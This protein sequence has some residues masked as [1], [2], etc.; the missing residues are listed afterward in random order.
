[1]KL[2]LIFFISLLSFSIGTFVGKQ[3]SDSQH[4]KVANDGEAD[5]AFRDTAS[6]DPKALDVAPQDALTEEDIANLEDEFVNTKKEDL[7]QAEAAKPTL[8]KN[9]GSETKGETKPAVKESG[10]AKS[11]EA[12]QKVAQRVA[13][14]KAPSE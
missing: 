14:G 3:F 1:M 2:V 13:E 8:A 11:L 10:V 4:K 6:V 12:V 5:E 7:A 9:T